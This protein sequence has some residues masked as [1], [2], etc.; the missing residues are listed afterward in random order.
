MS[1]ISR[2][3][4]SIGRPER[5]MRDDRVFVVSTEDTDA[6]E[7]YFAALP[8]PRVK[9][10]V[11]P[12]PR[13]SGQS[14]PEHVV[15]R[16]K[17]AF[18]TVRQRREVQDG[19]EFWVLLDTDHHVKGS[20]LRG[21]IGALKTATQAGFEVAVSNPCFDLWL[22]LHHAEMAPG[23]A[24]TNYREVEARLKAAL[25]GYDKTNLKS[26]HFSLSMVPAAIQRARALEVNPDNP[27][28]HWPESTGTRVYRLLERILEGRG[29]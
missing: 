24:M 3:P 9:V 10:L 15:D 5:Q 20:H 19:D 22:L 23:E 28:G 21:T 7:Q 4:I 17:E 6:P 12:T 8:L 13:N 1:L 29:K 26:A 11:L 16:L 2:K 27:T 18:E 25:G 14:S